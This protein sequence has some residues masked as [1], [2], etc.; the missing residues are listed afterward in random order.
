MKNIRVALIGYFLLT[1]SCLHQS[2]RWTAKVP[3]I[4]SD[5][6]ES[7]FMVV[8]PLKDK[9]QN[10][11]NAFM[12]DR[13]VLVTNAHVCDRDVA[14]PVYVLKDKKIYGGSIALID[15]DADMCLIESYVEGQPL[16]FLSDIDNYG[17]A[18]AVGYMP[19]LFGPMQIRIVIREI[20]VRN[21]VAH[22]SIHQPDGIGRRLSI[23]GQ[24]Q[25]GDSGSPIFNDDGYVI[26]MLSQVYTS[27]ESN[28]IGNGLAVA[29][30]PRTIFSVYQ[31]YCQTRGKIVVEPP[32]LKS[33]DQ[34]RI[35]VPYPPV[36]RQVGVSPPSVAP[37]PPLVVKTTVSKAAPVQVPPVAPKKVL[38][39]KKKK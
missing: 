5:I 16:S 24:F 34:D 33:D 12:I 2:P 3:T 27:R 10:M 25:R 28:Q 36:E 21:E 39:K 38:T 20:N 4:L 18:Y 15:E 37:M 29:I 31:H 7:V 13:N 35:T 14:A 19:D 23:D 30:D 26:G 6:K 32:P 17:H 11:G 1:V 22:H 9:T 8:I